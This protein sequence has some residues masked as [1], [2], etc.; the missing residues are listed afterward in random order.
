MDD[1]TIARLFLV[2]SCEILDQALIKVRH[3]LGQLTADQIAWRPH[4]DGNSIGNLVLHLCGNLQ[5]W[6]MSGI[7]G[8]TDTR[9]RQNEFDCRDAFD[10]D[11]LFQTVEA[12]VRAAQVLI[13]GLAANQLVERRTIQGFDVSV[14]QAIHHTTTHFVGH[15]HQIIYITRMILGDKY[16]M[17]WSPDEERGKLPI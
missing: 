14:L 11:S 9:D 15:T 12:T 7:G 5:Q 1:D 2:E 8:A 10:A 6:T 16:Q 17:R 3:C 13:S 4:P